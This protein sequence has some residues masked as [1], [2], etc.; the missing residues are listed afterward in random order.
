MADRTGGVL[1]G[2]TVEAAGPGL[3]GGSR[4]TVSDGAGRYTLDG[5]PAG[6]YTVSFTLSGFET[7]Q[8]GGVAVDAAEPVELARNTL[9]GSERL[10]GVAAVDGALL[11]RTGRELIR[12]G[13]AIQVN[14]SGW[15]RPA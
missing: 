5:L 13:L 14:R 8:R 6:D 2:V 15:V 4:T 7:L 9:T 10:Y 3:A 12:I 11:L 1:P